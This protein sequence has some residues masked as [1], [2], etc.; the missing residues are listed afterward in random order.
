MSDITGAE[1]VRPF[2]WRQE[3]APR[4]LTCRTQEPCWG[5]TERVIDGVRYQIV[6]VIREDDIAEC[7]IP[8]PNLPG[9]REFDIFCGLE[10]SVAEARDWADSMRE[11]TTWHD[12]LAEEAEKS[13]LFKR[14]REQVE[15]DALIVRN[16]STF[17]PGGKVQRN[18]FSHQNASKR[19]RTQH[20][21]IDLPSK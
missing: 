12:F 16:R 13:T 10:H 4:V 17:G 11:D 8:M 6:A 20:K 3:F 18:G 2:A 19:E 7:W 5:I 14:F 21:G 15:N 1:K 9:A